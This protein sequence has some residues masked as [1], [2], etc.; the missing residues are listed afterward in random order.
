[1]S[2]K[3]K[4]T[5]GPDKQRHHHDNICVPDDYEC[6]CMCNGI[7]V[8]LCPLHS[9]APELLEACKAVKDWYENAGH[10]DPDQ[11]SVGSV[12]LWS[13]C[14]AALLKAGVKP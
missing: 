9:A 1:M 5:P 14:K 8:I 11:S 6:G 12:E 3:P 10:Q 7:V 2:D 13:K 4:Y